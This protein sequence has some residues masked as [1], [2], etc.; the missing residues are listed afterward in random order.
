MSACIHPTSRPGVQT[1]A[2]AV[3]LDILPGDEPADRCGLANL[4]GECLDEGTRRYDA[5]GLATAAESLGATLDGN[6]RGG[7]V[8]CPAEQQQGAI[9]L[10]RE[11]LLEPTFPGREVRRVQAEILTELKTE[12]DD[13]R[14]VAARRFRRAIYGEHGV[15]G[16]RGVITYC[17]IGERSAHTWFVLHEL[18][19][20]AD[21][22]NYDGSWTEYGSL[23]GVP[24][25]LGDAPGEAL[26]G[27]A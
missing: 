12:E 15:E 21:V 14:V 2:C 27:V 22:R 5:L 24:V 4:V 7:V 3:S 17:R 23:V 9:A 18:L 6:H 16:A 8:L 26:G 19:D 1:W 11:L 20:Y 13:P 10:L 25:Q